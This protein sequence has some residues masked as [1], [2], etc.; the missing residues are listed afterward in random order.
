MN[1]CTLYAVEDAHVKFI[2]ITF[3]VI[4]QKWS[5]FAQENFLNAS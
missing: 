1:L 4:A 5:L 2:R 3:F